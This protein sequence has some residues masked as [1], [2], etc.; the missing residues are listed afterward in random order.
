MKARLLHVLELSTGPIRVANTF[1]WDEKATATEN[2]RDVQSSLKEESGYI[3][4]PNLS[5]IVK[6]IKLQIFYVSS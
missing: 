2:F 1:R 6:H 4:S 5:Q 3:L